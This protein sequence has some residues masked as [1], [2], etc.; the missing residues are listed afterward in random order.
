MTSHQ[1]S[2]TSA[3]F[4]VTNAG[5]YNWVASYS[6]DANNDGATGACGDEGETSTVNPATPSISTSATNAQL[7]GG[8]DPRRRDRERADRERDRHGDVQAVEQPEL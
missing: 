7:P 5:D 3:N 2:A 1:A 8:H 6:G 4:T